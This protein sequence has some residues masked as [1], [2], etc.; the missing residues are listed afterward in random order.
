MPYGM[1]NDAAT[2]R[3]SKVLMKSRLYVRPSAFMSAR[4]R[5]GD[6]MLRALPLALSAKAVG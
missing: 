5:L 3:G 6:V 2:E 4:R 1:L